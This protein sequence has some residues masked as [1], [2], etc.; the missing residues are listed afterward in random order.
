MDDIF[1]VYFSKLFIG[2]VRY[3]SVA[4]LRTVWGTGSIIFLV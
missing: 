3:A 1:T 4:S 2:H